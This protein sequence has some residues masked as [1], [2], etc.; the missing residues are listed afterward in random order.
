MEASMKISKESLAYQ[1]KAEGAEGAMPN[2]IRRVVLP[3][4]PKNYRDTSI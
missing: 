3:P 4:T 2:E 1:A